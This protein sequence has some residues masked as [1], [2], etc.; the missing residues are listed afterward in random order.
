MKRYFLLLSVA[1][2]LFVSCLYDSDKQSTEK[3]DARVKVI[4]NKSETPNSNSSDNTKDQMTV[5]ELRQRLN[6]IKEIE[7]ESRK[8][9]NNYDKDTGGSE[10]CRELMARLQPRARAIAD[11]YKRMLSPAGIEI[12][13]AAQSLSV[14]VMCQ[15]NDDGTD[16]RLARQAIN[17]A[18]TLL[19]KEA[20]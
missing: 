20:R 10:E 4:S 5:E 6:Q 15:R 16:C 11:E 17:K 7:H 13:S 12:A 9:W 18:E 14:C 19:K 2:F 8:K 3:P 1:C